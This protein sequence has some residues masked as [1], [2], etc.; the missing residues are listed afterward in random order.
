[1]LTLLTLLEEA[2]AQIY[3]EARG[4]LTANQLDQN[5]ESTTFE[6]MK[7]TNGGYMAVVA[8]YH[9][10]ENLFLKIGSELIQ[11][12]YCLK[13]APPFSSIYIQNNNRFLQIPLSIGTV[14]T[15]YKR[16]QLG[17]SPGIFY[18]YWLSSTIK[19]TVPNAFDSS[20]TFSNGG[21]TQN[22]RIFEYSTKNNL[23][24]RNYVRTGFGF[25]LEAGISY[26]I[27]SIWSLSTSINYQYTFTNQERASSNNR[28]SS[29]NRTLITSFG[30]LYRLR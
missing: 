4:G 10:K 22:F 8:T 26:S 9:I 27:N 29:S 14:V 12:N 7:F 16:I 20:N 6:N 25:F 11:K 23:A 18:S 13:R 24:Q 15:I 1:M 3:L 19:S 17:L 21:V 2:E 30:V 5:F 28:L